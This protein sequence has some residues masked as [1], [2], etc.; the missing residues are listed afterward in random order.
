[1]LAYRNVVMREGKIMKLASPAEN[2]GKAVN[3]YVA[4]FIGSPVMNF[5][6]G[7]IENGALHS[8]HR[9]LY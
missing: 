5:L 8:D 9:V 2:Y 1:M 4:D 7:R 3:K 6:E